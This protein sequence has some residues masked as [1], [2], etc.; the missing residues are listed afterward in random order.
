[1]SIEQ[2]IR[3]W[4]Q[5]SPAQQLELTLSIATAHRD[6]DGDGGRTGAD[7]RDNATTRPPHSA[8]RTVETSHGQLSYLE[9]APLLS[10]NAARIALSLTNAEQNASLD[11]DF[12]LSLHRQ[13]CLDLTPQFAGRWRQIE[14]QVGAHVPP[15]PYALPQLMRSYTLDLAA[16]IQHCGSEVER[17]LELLSFAEGRLLWIHP[18]ADF[19]GR[20]SRLFLGELLRRLNLPSLNLAFEPGEDAQNYFAALQAY[21]Q[22]N[23]A[24]LKRIWRQRF[25]RGV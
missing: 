23:T 20:V 2:Q 4:R 15:L 13:L 16:Q 21:D 12:I 3:A 25:E 10:D 5:L 22:R 11:D 19:N 1:M 24:P 17:L 14:A 18:F 9:L 8:T 7:Q 6:V